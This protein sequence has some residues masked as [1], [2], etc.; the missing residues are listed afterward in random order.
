LGAS[1]IAY[2]PG[3]TEEQLE[4]QPGFYNDDRA[5]AN[6]M[7]ECEDEPA[8]LDAVRRLSAQAILTYKTDPMEDDEVEF[9][10]P[11]QLRDAAM[12]LRDAV[13]N[14]AP[15]SQIV[16]KVYEKGANRI[17]PVRDEFV[18]DLDDVVALANWAEQQGASQ[19]TLEV[20][21]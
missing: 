16:L 6:W 4:T 9:V 17:D 10:T 15:E 14:G 5:W 20:N 1:V 21:W 13:L 12:K 18:R 11:Q 19:I 3:M 2:F 7:A 8:M